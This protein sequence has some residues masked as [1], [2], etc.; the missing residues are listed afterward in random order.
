M[1]LLNIVM[2]PRK[3]VDYEYLKQMEVQ[4]IEKEAEYKKH[5]AR[6]KED[7]K[8]FMATSDKELVFYSEKNGFYK[9]YAGIID[10]LLANSEVVIHYVTSD[11]N[12]DLFSGC[13]ERLIPYYVAADR[14]LIP[15][16]MRLD[17]K[18][19]VMT[20]P[21]LE[22]Y[23]LKRSRVNRNVEYIFTSHGMGSTALTLRKGALDWY[24]TIFCPGP[25]T[26]NEIRDAEELYHTS[27]KRLVETG[28]SL[29]DRMIVDYESTAHV[30][31]ETPRI[32]IAPSWQ[33]DNIIDLCVESLLDGLSVLKCEIILRPH[34]QQ[35]RHEP[36][37]F[38]LLKEKYSSKDNIEIQTDFSSTSPV[39]NSDL[40]ITDWS[41][42]SWEYAFVTLR[43]V[44]FINT[45]MKI[46]NPEYDRIKT[47]PINITLRDDI[48]RSIDLTEIEKVGAVAEDL[49]NKQ[50]EYKEEILKTRSEHLYNIGKSSR[51]SATYIIKSLNG[52]I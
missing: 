26:F 30:K 28:Y 24:D 5:H 18:I 4:R 32:L 14:Y 23:H 8:R 2:P 25:D 50:E 41:D 9:Y 38:V 48:G 40:L 15:L 51:L 20:V 27:K 45:P 44:L 47:K 6:E 46:M 13:P 39:F 37:K 52:D 22:K 31:N 7:Y 16:F 17:C 3:Y 49:L 35:V 19:C 43:P 29:I 33:P 11:P 36:E 42:I 12:D 10:C 1:L 21:D 34:P